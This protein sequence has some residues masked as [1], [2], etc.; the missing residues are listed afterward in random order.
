[1]IPRR[2]RSQITAVRLYG[3]A[4][5]R[6]NRGRSLRLARAQERRLRAARAR[7]GDREP[8]FRGLRAREPASPRGAVRLE[9]APG[10]RRR[11]AG[12]DSR[13]HHRR[14]RR[15]SVLAHRP[16]GEGRRGAVRDHDGLRS[17]RADGSASDRVCARCSTTVAGC[18]RTSSR[19]ARSRSATRSSSWRRA[20][21]KAS[22]PDPA[23]RRR[24]TKIMSSS[25]S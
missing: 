11:R 3:Y 10:D 4:A 24:Q 12:R 18:W 14:G 25:P 20:G 2:T 6:G 16:A 1:M 9:G 8:G 19:V 17:V 21:S 5:L 22:W 13:E 7:A 23:Q 15:R